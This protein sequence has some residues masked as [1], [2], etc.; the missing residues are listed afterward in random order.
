MARIARGVV[1]GFLYH[2]A[3][4]G[5]RRDSVFFQVDDYRLYR[6]LIAAAARRAGTAVW[7]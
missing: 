1:P 2:V 4:R 5:N 7:A 6:R 3:Q